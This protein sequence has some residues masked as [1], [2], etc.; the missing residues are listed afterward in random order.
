MT[1]RI[2]S[3]MDGELE[4]AD[5]QRVIRECCLSGKDRETWH[6]YHVIGDSMRGQAPR[7]LAPARD[8]GTMLDKE[9]AIIA[10]PRRVLETPMARVA[11]AAA[12]SVATIGVVGWIGSQG[13]QLGGGAP[14]VAKTPASSIQPVANSVSARPAPT[15]DVQ[16]YYVAHKQLPSP[17]IYRPVSNRAV[18]AA[19][20]R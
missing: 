1:E 16:D 19:A 3:L 10:R 9:P 7:Q 15:V 13:G 2:S 18:P 6:L 11:L 5:A 4:A 20:A 8:I 17:E 12:A 14:T